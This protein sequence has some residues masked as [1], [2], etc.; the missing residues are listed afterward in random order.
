MASCRRHG[1][2]ALSTID[3]LGKWNVQ[4]GCRDAQ[5]VVPYDSNWKRSRPSR[6]SMACALAVHPCSRCQRRPSQPK[7]QTPKNSS[8]YSPMQQTPIITRSIRVI[9]NHPSSWLQYW[10]LTD[11]P[12]PVVQ[13]DAPINVLD[14]CLHLRKRRHRLPRGT[15]SPVPLLS[16]ACVPGVFVV[17]WPSCNGPG[18]SGVPVGVLGV[19]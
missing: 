1:D 3:Q 18:G 12:R 6:P 14:I 4:S 16:R 2:F 5:Q 17:E 11:L 19:D 7:Q 8:R 13:A 15:P 10:G 9:V